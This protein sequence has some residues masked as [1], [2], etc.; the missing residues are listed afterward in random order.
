VNK[1]IT[2]YYQ[3]EPYLVYK[4]VAA[5]L[6]LLDK[7]QMVDKNSFEIVCLMCDAYKELLEMDNKKNKVVKEESNEMSFSA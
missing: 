6:G 7:D 5:I 3:K 2:I 4:E 1:H